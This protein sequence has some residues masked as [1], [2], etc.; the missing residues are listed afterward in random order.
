MATKFKLND[1]VKVEMVVPQGPVEKF[2]MLSDGTI[3]CL[4]SWTDANGEKK[5]R[6]FPEDQLTGV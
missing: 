2:M 6:W 1:E 3:M 5:S 4:I